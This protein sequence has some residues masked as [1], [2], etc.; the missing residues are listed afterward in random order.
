MEHADDKGVQ[1]SGIIKME[2]SGDQAAAARNHFFYKSREDPSRN[3]AI[4]IMAVHE[5]SFKYITIGQPY[6]IIYATGTFMWIL[7]LLFANTVGHLYTV[8][9]IH[10]QSQKVVDNNQSDS[11][12]ILP[13][14]PLLFV[15]HN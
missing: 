11:G 13:I 8:Y 2:A 4:S 3:H 6:I 5:T 12:L 7:G 9:Y 14:V 1:L 15:Q 10:S